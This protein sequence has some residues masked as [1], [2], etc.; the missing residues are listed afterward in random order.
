MQNE[1]FPKLPPLTLEIRGIP[2]PV[3]KYRKTPLQFPNCHIPSKK[4]SK[5]VLDKLPNGRRLDRAMVVM[6]PEIRAWIEKAEAHL[7][8][9]L[10]SMCRT[11]EGETQ[12]AL[13][14]LSV[15]LSQ[16]PAD[17]SVNDFPQGTWKVQLCEPG[18]EGASV[19]I[20]RL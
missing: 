6:K 13:S 18:N 5:M 1:L 20:E 9:Q 17:D 16:L 11:T 7:E 10:L 14:K 3:S 4:N 8:S 15:I 2:M 12:S 19:T